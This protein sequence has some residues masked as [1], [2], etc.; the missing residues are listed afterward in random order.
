MDKR[1][2]LIHLKRQFNLRFVLQWLLLSAVTGSIIGVVTA[3]FLVSLNA[4]TTWRTAH[5]YITWLLPLGGL[6]VVALYHYW[7]ATVIR[8]NNQLIEEIE[9]PQHIVP[10]RMAP[11]V[12]AGT[13]ITHLFGGSAGRE[14][15]AVQMGGS[16]AD[17]FSKHF[18]LSR[19][20]RQLL[21]MAG[22]SA[23]FA[24]VFGT[25]LAGAVFALEVA[26]IGRIRFEGIIPTLLSAFIANYVC[27]LFPV[28]HTV[29]SLGTI[30]SWS[31]LGLLAAGLAGI[32]FGLTARCFSLLTESLA[33]WQRKWMSN[34][35]LRV[36]AGSLLLLVL[37]HLPGN[38]KYAGLGI[39]TI[40]ASFT[41]QQPGYVFLLKLVLTAL[42]L[43]CGFKGGEVTPLFFV[44]ATLGSA[45][46]LI[47][48]LPVGLLAGMGFVA[49]FCGAAN[50]PFA[51][52]IMGIELFGTAG[53]IY[54]TIACAFA[55]LFSGH[56]GIYHAQKV[57]RRK[58][59]FYKIPN[60]A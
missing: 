48:P 44:G 24:G 6:L 50:T 58:H 59:P 29:Y 51:C 15:T 10:L 12:L 47:L 13:L 23:G 2:A 21:L 18:K 41:M 46:S 45:L 22:I 14:G 4:V 28:N 33:D 35:F 9:K 60:K 52:I 27:E 54:I 8:G 55:Y 32:L 43:S 57:G 36:I 56:K 25:P 19:R 40:S 34:P 42:T 7:G 31:F 17:Q 26:V 49:V 1:L 53:W 3:A 38:E 37:L 16:I 30:H 5:P 20:N 39:P 11:L